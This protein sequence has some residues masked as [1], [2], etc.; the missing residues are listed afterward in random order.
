MSELLREGHVN[1]IEG[2]W[3]DEWD[4]L[5]CADIA[6]FQ[7]PMSAKCLYQ[8]AMAKDL[9]LKV[10]IDL[11]D[12]PE[13][14]PHHEVYDLWNEEYDEKT[15]FK[16][17][18]LADIVTVSTKYLKNYYLKFNNNVVI[19]PNA[20]ND[21]W[22]KFSG[23]SSKKTVVWRGGSHHLT[24]LYEYKNEIIEVMR[25]HPDWEFV[26][27]GAEAKFLSDKLSNYEY[28]GDFN[29]HSYFGYILR[30]KPSIFVVPLC[31]NEL[32]RGKSSISWQE[33]TLCGAVSLT[34]SYWGL[35]DLSMPYNSKEQFKEG[36]ERLITDETLRYNL[37]YKSKCKIEDKFVLSKVNKQR[38]SII[39][40][41]M[42]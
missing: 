24:D 14:P 27:I 39:K 17:M 22:L 4:I 15:F 36:F 37:H 33:A 32:N 18:M 9:G 11:D 38:L 21:Y 8:I 23:L 5:R 3:N 41:L 35:R 1:L 2:T 20:I 12:S 40:N 13:I 25:A 29:I 34:P 10:W 30:N 28:A 42:G 6:F 19:L 16:I 26:C 7:R 31:D